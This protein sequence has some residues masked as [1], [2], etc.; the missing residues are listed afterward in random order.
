M[1]PVCPLYRHYTDKLELLF[2]GGA[3]LEAAMLD[4]V[5]AEP[6]TS[7]ETALLAAALEGMGG[8]FPVDRRTFSRR[9]QRILDAEPA[10]QEREMATALAQALTERHVPTARARLVAELALGVFRAS[11]AQWIAV[12]PARDLSEIQRDALDEW[13]ALLGG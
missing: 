7:S 4:A 1:T 6:E 9:R 3:E 8:C 13:H 2:D 12:E 5:R 10:L 11:S